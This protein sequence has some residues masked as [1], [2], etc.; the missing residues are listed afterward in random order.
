MDEFETEIPETLLTALDL[1]KNAPKDKKDILK[2]RL[3][4][5]TFSDT[6]FVTLPYDLAAQPEELKFNL[7]FFSML[8]AHINR[9]MFEIGLPIRGA[10]HTFNCLGKRNKQSNCAKWQNW[11]REQT[12]SLEQTGRFYLPC[13]LEIVF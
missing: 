5:L 2:N 1:Q 3:R 10:V 8:V 11:C 13:P 4:W 12:E 9:R 7:L 6:I